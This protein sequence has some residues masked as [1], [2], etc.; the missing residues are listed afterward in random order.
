LISP[1]ARH[2]VRVVE[3]AFAL[4]AARVMLRSL[5]FTTTMKLVGSGE[6]S[7]A[8]EVVPRRT[9]DPVAASVGVA[10]KRAAARLPW[11][12]TCLARS[13]AGRLMLRRRG[14]ASTIVFGVAK[15]TEHISGHAWL[16]AAGGFVCGGHEAHNFQ[17]IAAFKNRARPHA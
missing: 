3:A 7:G 15:E 5:P 2:R 11:R 17:P 8:D 4:V 6:A 13:L 1:L 12:F 14:V 10:L 9:T 16:V